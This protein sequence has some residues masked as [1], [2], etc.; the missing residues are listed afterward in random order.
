MG[1]AVVAAA[2]IGRLVHDAEILT[3]KGES[4]R[5]KDKNLAEPAARRVMVGAES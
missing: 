4:Y 2:M 5:L 3:L 1:D